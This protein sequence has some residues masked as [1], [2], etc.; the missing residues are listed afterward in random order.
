MFA[1]S[2]VVIIL[3]LLVGVPTLLGLLISLWAGYFEHL[4]QA[5]YVPF[6]EADLRAVRPWESQAQ[7]QARLLTYGPDIFP[8]QAW[9][10]W[11]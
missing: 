4:D 7:M 6:D 8:P 5:A 11:L 3:G 9:K 2:T 10:P 1:D